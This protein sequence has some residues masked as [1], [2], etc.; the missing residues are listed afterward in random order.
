MSARHPAWFCVHAL[1]KH[2]HIAAAQLAQLPGIEVFL[3]RVRYQRAT[4]KGPAWVTEAL[5]LN[6]LFARFDLGADL[7]R[8][9]AARGVRAVVRF[10]TQWPVIPDA[11]MKELQ[12]TMGPDPVR[13]LHQD[14]R[15]GEPVEI[16]GG[17]FHGLQAV[18]TRTLKPSQ[19][20]AVL[21]EFLG[22]QTSVE[23]HRTQVIRGQDVRVTPENPLSQP[24]PAR[25]DKKSH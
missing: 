11:A 20:V 25:K 8:I 22:R 3:P 1:N 12:D 15:E 4:R 16:Q 13:I 24:S 9:Q 17:V 6:Y 18:V 7:R 5:F 2:E 19:R 14:L 21:L 10:G 23:L